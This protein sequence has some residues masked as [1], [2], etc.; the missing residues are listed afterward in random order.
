MQ[1]KVKKIQS[2]MILLPVS[3]FFS[4]RQF[5]TYVLSMLYIFSDSSVYSSK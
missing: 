1:S 5:Y 4:L 3:Y 2:N